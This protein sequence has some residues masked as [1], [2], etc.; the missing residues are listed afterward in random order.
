MQ[1]DLYRQETRSD[2]SETFDDLIDEDPLEDDDEDRAPFQSHRRVVQDQPE[3][4][5]R[6]A[7]IRTGSGW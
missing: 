2:T 7:H 3:L 5:L 4:N 6:L 1:I